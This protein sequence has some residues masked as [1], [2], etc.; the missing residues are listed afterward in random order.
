MKPLSG[1]LLLGIGGI[2]AGRDEGDHFFFA[3]EQV[4]GP[5]GGAPR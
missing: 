2:N 5:H 1:R 3:L 4:T